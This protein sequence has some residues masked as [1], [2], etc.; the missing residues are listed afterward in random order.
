MHEVGLVQ[1]EEARTPPFLKLGMLTA[2][3]TL[4]SHSSAY[5]VLVSAPSSMCPTARQPVLASD[6]LHEIPSSCASA[7]PELLWV[8][9]QLE[10]FHVSINVS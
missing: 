2:D 6:E 10:P 9:D 5:G 1:S 4:P 7:V 8:T 3:Q